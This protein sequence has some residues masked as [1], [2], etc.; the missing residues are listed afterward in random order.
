MGRFYN[1]YAK[2]FLIRVATV[3]AGGMVAYLREDTIDPSNL[4]DMKALAYGA[5]AAGFYA[6]VAL[7]SPGEPH[8]GPVKTPEA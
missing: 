7:I 5:I 2:R 3:F 1:T 4:N 6:L 8:V